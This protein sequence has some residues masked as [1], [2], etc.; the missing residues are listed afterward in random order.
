MYMMSTTQTLPSSKYFIS[1]T[2]ID[3]TN[4]FLDH[5]KERKASF[6]IVFYNS[7]IEIL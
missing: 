3:K 6:L 2:V 4:N 7:L 1:Y 5:L